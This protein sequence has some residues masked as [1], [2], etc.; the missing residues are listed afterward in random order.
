MTDSLPALLISIPEGVIDLGWGHPSSRLHPLQA[1]QQ[2]ATHMMTHTGVAALQY[3]AE[4]GFGPLLESLAAF[5]SQPDA[6]DLRVEPETLFLTC[7]ASQALDLAC[8]LLTHAGD[9]VFVEEPTYYLVQRIFADHHL[10]VIGVPTDTDGLCP[11]ALEALLNDPAVPR[12]TLLYTIPTFQNPSGSVL[13]AERRPVLVDLAQRYAFTVLADEVYHLLY[14][15]A[16]PPPPLMAFD[17]SEQGCVI[18]LGSF[19]KILAPGLRA[20]WIQANPV[21]LQRFVHAGMI[22][23]GGGLNQF[24]ASLIH[25]TLDLGLLAQNLTIL[26]ATYGKRVQALTAA[27]QTHL[28]HEV[29]FTPPAGG[30]FFW[31]TCPNDVDT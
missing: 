21:L 9:T 26:K 19:S 22:A 27:L 1:V 25:A 8:T 18:S 15:D 3:G 30:Y 20:G 31:L 5:L 14:Y 24:I 16:P 7:G 28:A 13:S 23:S 10:N 11:D 2:A 17:D 12:P 29:D 4:Q 6:Y